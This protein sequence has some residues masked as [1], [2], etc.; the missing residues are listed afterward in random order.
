MLWYHDHAMGINR[1]NIYAG[2]LGTYIVRDSVEDALNLP[3]GKYEIPLV[4]FDRLFTLD[5]QLLYPVSGDPAAPWVP[6][7]FGDAIL[8]NG[9]L[10]PYFEV[11]PRRYRFRLLNGSNGRFYHLSLGDGV[12]FF[13]DRY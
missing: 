12:R 3:K 5:H 1:L 2:L 4:I 8:V 6:E 13:Q 11:E 10:F 7:V 9:K